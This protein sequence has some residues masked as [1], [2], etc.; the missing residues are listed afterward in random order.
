MGLVA[1]V[2]SHG[3]S[4]TLSKLGKAKSSKPASMVNRKLGEFIRSRKEF[5]LST[6]GKELVSLAK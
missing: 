5:E 6:C 2:K 3:G 4:I 1:T